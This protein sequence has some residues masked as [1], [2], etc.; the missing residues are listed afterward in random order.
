MK[1]LLGL[2][3]AVV[4]VFSMAA[5]NNGDKASGEKQTLEV[6]LW[7]ESVSEALEA[8]I[9]KF[10]EKHPDVEVKITISPYGEYWTKLK[11][12]LGGGSGPDVFW[13]N[14]PNFYQYTTTGLIKDLDPFIKK[15][16]N[17]NT[18]NYYQTLLDLYSYEG[19][20]YA[21]PYFFDSV[22]L[23]YNKEMFDKAGVAYPDETWT[24]DDL[25]K[26]GKTLSNP[27]EGVYGY[28]GHTVISQ[29]GYYNIIHQAGG[30]II[31]DDKTKSGFDLPETKEAFHFLQRL[32]DEGISPSTQKQIET[33]PRDLF[34]SNKMAMLPA[35]STNSGLLY[36]ALGEN[37]GVAPL[38][39]GKK[40]AS[41]IHGIAWSMNAKAKNEDLAWD[42]ITALTNEEGNRA[43]AESGYTMPANKE[44][45]SLWTESIPS[46]NLQVFIDA[47]NYGAVY[48]ISKN[49]AEWQAIETKEIQSALLENRSID[50]ALDKVA[51]EMNKIL[52]EENKE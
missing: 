22:G 2:C 8:S 28:A 29:E 25:E 35:V 23:F 52:A 20:L 50:E 32:I 33:H 19:K 49:T 41:I 5:C 21:A 7:S 6:A 27:D 3:L 12:S 13:M 11:T 48:P 38:P 18:E 45:S 1:K 4:L 51:E 40:A 37:L 9:A 24:W 17:Y 26:V 43:I 30:H 36:E 46:L 15:S 16:D 34:I 47:Q 42:L 44:L 14:G 31:S 10:N 39:K